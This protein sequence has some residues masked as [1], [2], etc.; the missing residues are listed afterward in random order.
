MNG[1]GVMGEALLCWPPLKAVSNIAVSILWTCGFNH[2]L[3]AFLIPWRQMVTNTRYAS[4]FIELKTSRA[5]ILFFRTWCILY[6]YMMES[7]EEVRTVNIV[8][9]SLSFACKLTS[10]FHVF[11]VTL[12]QS[13]YWVKGTTNNNNIASFTSLW[14][15]W[16]DSA[17]IGT[18]SMFLMVRWPKH[19]N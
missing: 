12:I 14:S 9:A 11:A 4:V 19:L 2:C 16:V 15:K 1:K 5:F 10:I 3:W 18:F 17:G 7:L 13:D 8:Q 6:R